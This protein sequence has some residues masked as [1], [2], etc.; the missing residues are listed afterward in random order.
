MAAGA[1]ACKLVELLGVRLARLQRWRHQF[2]GDGDGL[3]RCKGSPS[4]VS[5]RLTEEGRQRILLTCN[6]PEFAAMPPG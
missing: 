1:R 4:L 2:A 6:Q 3:D 5:H